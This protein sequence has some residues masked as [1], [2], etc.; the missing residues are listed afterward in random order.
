MEFAAG[1]F[2]WQI[3]PSN[4]DVR[5][6][7]EVFQ[8]AQHDD[9]LVEY[10]RK[11]RKGLLEQDELERVL[12]AEWKAE[13]ASAETAEDDDAV[14]VDDARNVVVSSPMAAN[15]WK[16][17]VQPGDILHDGQVVAILEAMKM[18]V[19]VVA[20]TGSN[21]SRVRS[22]LKKP[23]SIASAGDILLVATRPT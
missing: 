3:S 21:G 9:E 7:Y 11:Q 15:V 14:D 4:F 2:K 17:E 12:Y 23:K 8:S 5:E 20:P 18:E 6:V 1:K 22:I 16:V 13:S 19:N 10:K